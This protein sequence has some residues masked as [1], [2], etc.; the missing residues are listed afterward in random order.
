M[1]F[2]S[3]TTTV[4]GGSVAAARLDATSG[5][6]DISLPDG[7]QPSALAGAANESDALLPIRPVRSPE[8]VPLALGWVYSQRPPVFTW[9]HLLGVFLLVIVAAIWVGASELVQFIFGSTGS[10]P[11]LFITT[12][13]VS[14]F[15]VLL[16]LE[17][18]REV[19][20][21]HWWPSSSQSCCNSGDWIR[22]ARTAAVVAPIWVVAQSTYNWALAGVSVSVS[23]VLSTTSCVWTFLLSLIFLGER[24][25]W[26]KGAGVTL[27]LGG[28]S[29]VALE[30]GG[31]DAAWWGIALSLLSAVAYGCYTTA[32]RRLAPDGGG[33][34]LQLLF[35]FIGVFC[36]CTLGPLTGTLHATGVLR[37]PPLDGGLM[38]LILT[39][40]LTDN[41]L[42]DLLWAWAIQLTSATLATVGLALTIP[43]AMVADLLIDGDVPGPSLAAGSCLVVLGFLL[44]SVSPGGSSETPADAAVDSSAQDK[45]AEAVELVVR[46]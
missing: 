28:A 20:I 33:V 36:A 26:V 10:T 44:T 4:A 11:W 29:I 6:S 19:V 7:L 38:G 23:T 43:L 14:E 35:G 45:V 41:V 13:N 46:R 25:S 27:T 1:A 15:A 32:L 42:S 16:P 37:V 31:T 18:V 40:G 2:A 3:A 22:A 39:K 21:L 12:V 24:F 5:D 17:A 9:R 34:R 30:G 8:A